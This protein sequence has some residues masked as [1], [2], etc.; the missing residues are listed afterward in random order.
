MS[1]API[2]MKWGPTYTALAA[3]RRNYNE[4][5]KDKETGERCIKKEVRSNHMRLAEHLIRL[6]SQHID[7][8]KVFYLDAMQPY[9]TNNGKLADILGVAKRSV[10]NHMNR[11]VEAGII[12]YKNFRGSYAD[13]EIHLNPAIIDVQG[14]VDDAA[15]LN[16]ELQD[17]VNAEILE[18][19]TEN[20]QNYPH[21]AQTLPLILEF[22]KINKEI[23]TNAVNNYRYSSND[24]RK[25]A[26][27]SEKA[28]KQPE[29]GE[30][31]PDNL[32]KDQ[33]NLMLAK[34]LFDLSKSKMFYRLKFI[35]DSEE[36]LARTWFFKQ[37]K[38][39]GDQNKR[40]FEE[41]TLRI[42][43]VHEFL[44]NKKNS[45]YEFQERFVPIP[46]VFFSETNKNGFVQ[47][48]AWLLE[49]INKL[50]WKQDAMQKAAK[51]LK[52]WHEYEK[53]GGFDHDSSSDYHQFQHM[54]KKLEKHGNKDLSNLFFTQISLQNNY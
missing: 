43:L 18:L 54:K 22:Y 4:G 44:T 51:H 15:K 46:S 3:Y 7:K 40:V 19:S 27:L 11:L 30:S 32:A 17:T 42:H 13:Y 21:I 26:V 5:L 20:D 45:K 25:A 39:S 10:V 48:K 2:K 12:S 9:R 47:T 34:I 16:Q 37:L 35:S 53:I 6:Y 24:T 29:N 36:K 14:S 8:Q 41:L 38:K 52:L 23:V 28:K 49:R 33:E 31:L 1:A 50:H